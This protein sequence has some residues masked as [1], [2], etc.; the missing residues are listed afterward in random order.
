MMFYQ[1]PNKTRID[2]IITVEIATAEAI[3]RFKTDQ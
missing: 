2:A 3:D 1:I